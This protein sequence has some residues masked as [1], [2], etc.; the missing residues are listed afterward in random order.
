V[1][2]EVRFGNEAF[3][4]AAAWITASTWNRRHLLLN[5]NALSRS[6]TAI[7]IDLSNVDAG[8]LRKIRSCSAWD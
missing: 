4:T 2:G 3:Q 7:R 5:P 1:D 8:D 6:T